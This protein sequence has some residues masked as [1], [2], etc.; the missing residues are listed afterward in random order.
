LIYRFNSREPKVQLD[1]KLDVWFNIY[2]YLNIRVLEQFVWGPHIFLLHSISKHNQYWSWFVDLI[3][4]NIKVQSD[5]KL[6]V[7][8]NEHCD[9]NIRTKKKGYTLSWCLSAWHV[10]TWAPSHAL[11]APAL[12]HYALQQTAPGSFLRMKTIIL[13]LV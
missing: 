13:G 10:L 11:L 1:Y 6:D 7:W 4:R 12:V 2:I 3:I 5:Y 8:F 9:L